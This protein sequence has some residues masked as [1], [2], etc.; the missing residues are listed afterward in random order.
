MFTPS[1]IS[2]DGYRLAVGLMLINA[3][4]KVFVGKRVDLARLSTN[5]ADGWQMPQGGIDIGETPLQ[6]TFRELK[7]EVGSDK[8]DL[9]AE[10]QYWYDYRLPEDLGSKLWGGRFHSIR[11]RWFLLR[12]T[13]EDRDI[14]LDAYAYP[15][16]S[17]WKWVPMDHL[18][19]L[20]VDFKK[21]VYEQVTKEFK[22]YLV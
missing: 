2:V 22:E 1:D 18:V 4:N 19:G 12:F 13:G 15:E 11:Q 7:E 14:Q 21:N 6:A 3:D 17:D 5:K 10:S 9:I 20:I 16:F 8:A